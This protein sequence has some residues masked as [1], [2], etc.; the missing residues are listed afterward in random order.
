LRVLVVALF[1]NS[2][3]EHTSRSKLPSSASV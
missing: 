3:R 2:F 1:L